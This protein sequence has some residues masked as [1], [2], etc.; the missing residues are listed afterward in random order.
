MRQLSLQKEQLLCATLRD[1]WLK[2]VVPQLETE[3]GSV[4]HQGSLISVERA[5]DPLAILPQ[6]S[7]IL[8]LHKLCDVSQ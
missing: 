5:S 8:A 1:R 2:S 4:I 6:L 3:N 7:L